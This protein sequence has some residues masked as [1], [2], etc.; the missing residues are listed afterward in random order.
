MCTSLALMTAQKQCFFG[1]TM[2]FHYEIEPRLFV[3]PAN[4]RWMGAAG[5]PM[6]SPYRIMGVGQEEDGRIALFDGVNEHGLAAAALYFAGHAEFE[7][8]VRSNS[9]AALDLV[10][11]MLGRFRSVGELREGIRGISITGA[12]DTVTGGVAPL[13]WMVSDRGG[14]HL[15]I[16]RTCRGLEL[17]ENPAGVMTNSPDFRWQMLNLNNYMD[18]S[19]YQRSSAQWGG[20]TLRPFGMS[21]GTA[22]L[23]GGYTPPARFVRAAFNRAFAPT[24]RSAREAVCTFFHLME[25]V[26]LPK[27]ISRVREQEYDFTVYTCCVDTMH[28]VYY[29]RT[30]ENS[31]T[32]TAALA[33]YP[34]DCIMDLGPLRIPEEYGRLERK[35]GF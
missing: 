8:A 26:S 28:G 27:G 13:H 23:P 21:N 16:E 32:F 4:R 17:F 11:Y 12:A 35:K 10:Q 2:D 20:V 31:R 18:A 34:A 14:H 30:Y 3:L 22:P 29:W 6:N 9:V 25:S 7:R 19:P 5:I 33:D 15:V 24:P 1:R